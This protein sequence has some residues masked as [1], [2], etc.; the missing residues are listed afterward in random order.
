MPKTIPNKISGLSRYNLHG[1]ASSNS[2]VLFPG[3]GI[4]DRA[5]KKNPALDEPGRDYG[6]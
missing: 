3:W 4:S 5:G 1:L 6:S 2:E